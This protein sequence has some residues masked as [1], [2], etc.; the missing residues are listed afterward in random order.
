MKVKSLSVVTSNGSNW[1]KD[2]EELGTLSSN[3][4]VGDRIR[5]G[6]TNLKN[7][8]KLD[9]DGN[10]ELDKDGNPKY[11]R[12]VIFIHEKTSTDGL[13]LI[14]SCSAGLSKVIRKAVKDGKKK[15]DLLRL[16]MTFTIIKNAQGT[17]LN[18]STA[19]EAGITKTEE[20]EDKKE[21][22]FTWEALAF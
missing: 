18:A 8:W 6:N 16:L 11:V 13:P 17:Y 20:E 5:F 15:D 12:V 1:A 2:V 21:L 7:E 4:E 10:K 19:Q 9:K 14:L 22:A 3:L